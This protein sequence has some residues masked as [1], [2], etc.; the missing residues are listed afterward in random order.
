MS[1]K[2]GRPFGG[3][4]NITQV[5]SAAAKTALD[6]ELDKLYALIPTAVQ[7]AP[8]GSGTKTPSPDFERIHPDQAQAIRAELDGFKAAYQ[9]A[10]TS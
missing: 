3:Y 4:T 5:I 8:P 7:L 6:T 2:Y 10:P 9:A 1:D